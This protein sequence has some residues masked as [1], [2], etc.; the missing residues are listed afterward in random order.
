MLH[1]LE[2]LLN[3]LMGRETENEPAE[4]GLIFHLTSFLDI[5]AFLKVVFNMRYCFQ[6]QQEE[7]EEFVPMANND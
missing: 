7:M 5:S 4:I 6:Q 1:Q 3:F 2:D